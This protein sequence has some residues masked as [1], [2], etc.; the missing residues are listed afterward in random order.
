MGDNKFSF[1]QKRGR[2]VYL[3]RAKCYCGV[4]YNEHDYCRACSILCGQ[5]HL[6]ASPNLY[7]GHPVC[8]RCRDIW[9]RLEKL[10]GRRVT[11]AFL[12]KDNS[13]EVLAL[14]L[15]RQEVAV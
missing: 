12:Q 7:R 4:Q 14:I 2:P 3:Q 8:S 15:D 13:D 10:L 11:I 5:Y 1:Q 9:E 6:T